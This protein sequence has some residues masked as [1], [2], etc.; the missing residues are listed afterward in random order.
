M[1][2]TPWALCAQVGKHRL[3]RCGR[4]GLRCGSG[5]SVN[6]WSAP[7]LHQQHQ[8]PGEPEA[9]LAGA[10]CQADAEADRGARE[11]AVCLHR[12]KFVFTHAF[13]AACFY[14]LRLLRGC[15]GRRRGGARNALVNCKDGTASCPGANNTGSYALPRVVALCRCTDLITCAVVQTQAPRRTILPLRHHLQPAE[16]SRQRVPNSAKSWQIA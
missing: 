15:A 2:P 10:A 6:R 8:R 5:S 3:Q 4:L 13:A 16:E 11:A 7:K 1:N 9:L 14:K 12:R